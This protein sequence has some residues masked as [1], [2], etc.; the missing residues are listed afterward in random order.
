MFEVPYFFLW[1]LEGLGG[2]FRFTDLP[3]AVPLA[4]KL[5]VVVLPRFKPPS[6]HR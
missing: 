4:L 3:F 1:P 6:P 5:I 2:S